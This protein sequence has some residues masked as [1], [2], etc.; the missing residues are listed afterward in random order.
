MGIGWVVCD[1]R[2]IRFWHDVWCGAC[3]MKVLF[4]KLFFYYKQATR[5]I[6]SRVVELRLG[7]N[8]SEELWSCRA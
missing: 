1:G 6:C 7:H 8:L 5:G 2:K 4:P 3:P